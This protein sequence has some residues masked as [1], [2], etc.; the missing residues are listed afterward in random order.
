MLRHWSRAQFVETFLLAASVIGLIAIFINELPSSSPVHQL[1]V[2]RSTTP[3]DASNRLPD[4]TR[5]QAAGSQLIQPIEEPKDLQYRID[6]LEGQ[7]KQAPAAAELDKAR[8]Q[9]DEL[10]SQLAKATEQSK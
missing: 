1:V 4:S 10:R 9:A 6:Q 8:K 3:S 2:P 7:L 5:G